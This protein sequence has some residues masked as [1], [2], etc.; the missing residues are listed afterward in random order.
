M[1]WADDVRAA[2][3]KGELPSNDVLELQAIRLGELILLAVPGELYVE[4]GLER[5]RLSPFPHTLIAGYANGMLGYLCTRSWQQ[6]AGSQEKFISLRLQSLAADTEDVIY[7]T[8][9][10][11]F[12]RLGSTLKPHGTQAVGLT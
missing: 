5:K 9:L 12:E 2:R 6:Q 7:K 4:I 8:A 1:Q 3:Q 11:L 10:E